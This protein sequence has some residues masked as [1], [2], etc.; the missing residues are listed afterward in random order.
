MAPL[1]AVN[2]YSIYGARG[3]AGSDGTYRNREVMERE[4]EILDE[5]TANRDQRIWAVAQGKS[6]RRKLMTATP[7]PSSR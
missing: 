3:E 6:V 2:G 1:P 7:S 4:R 5:M